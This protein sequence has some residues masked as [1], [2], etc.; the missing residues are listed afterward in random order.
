[1]RKKEAY[2]MTQSLLAQILRKMVMP[3]IK[4]GLWGKGGERVGL[5][6]NPVFG[7]T[8]ILDA[9]RPLGLRMFTESWQ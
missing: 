2:K 1:M 5:K 4:L 3:H 8:G 7:L 9:Y 6:V